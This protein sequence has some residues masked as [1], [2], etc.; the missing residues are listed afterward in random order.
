MQTA[1]RV[2]SDIGRFHMEERRR[3]ALKSCTEKHNTLNFKNLFPNFQ[4]LSVR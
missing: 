1:M 2:S 3:A 4:R